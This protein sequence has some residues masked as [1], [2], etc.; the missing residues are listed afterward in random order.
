MMGVLC[1]ATGAAAS[2]WAVDP[3]LPGANRAGAGLSLFEEIT[4]DGVPFPYEALM[5][6]IEQA[7]GCAPRR[8]TTSVLIPLGR[9][10]QRTAAAP[11]YFRYP[12][13]VTAVIDD[14]ATRLHAK[15]RLFIGYQERAELIEVISY[16]ETAGRF[17]F[18]LVRDYR[19]GGERRIVPANRAVCVACHQNHAPIFSRQQWD[20]TN[21]NPQIADAIAARQPSGTPSLY[22]VAI[23]GGVD[24]P[25]AIDDAVDRANLIAVVQRIWREAC[26][27]PCRSAVVAAALQYRLS[28]EQGFDARTNLARGFA[29]SWPEG[30]AVPDPD[31]PNRDPLAIAVD[32]TPARRIDVP[33]VFDALKVRGPR[34]VWKAGDALLE[35]RFV[36]GLATMIADT[37]VSAVESAMANVPAPRRVLHAACSVARGRASCDGEFTLAATGSFVERLV[38]GGGELTEL[39]LSGGAL[40]RRGKPAR[41]IAGERIERLEVK[42]A[43]GGA[44]ATLTLVEDFPLQKAALNRAEWTD[45]FTR[46]A[47][48][49]TLGLPVMAPCCKPAAVP[50]ADDAVEASGVA[51]AFSAPC[52]SCH[53]GAER[54]PP[55]FLAGDSERVD[56]ALRR[57]AQRMF[58][59][60][61]MWQ[62]APTARA[63]VPMPPPRAALN[64]GPHEQLKPDAAI[65]PL[66]ATVAEW[67]RRE[68]GTAP[69]VDTL[70]ARGYENLRPCLPPATGD[71]R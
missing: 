46:R 42:P 58:V 66:Q 28:Q 53:R 32:L 48:R 7:T 68:S 1:G 26:D 50:T 25:N 65:A 11:D 36:A 8:C 5:R 37:D 29:K 31:L 23:R 67:L 51:A 4:A 64:G 38:I 17:E 34:D 57:C 33:A 55:N 56:A 47:L 61:A 12:R 3:S 54:S 45:V 22:G 6:K 13:V 2:T 71:A 19:A 20:E 24:L 14:G 35:A 10:L 52:G 70:L 43:A 49:A 18:Q 59:R 63:K 44:R 30:L 41:T 40:S 15:D 9:S 16:N 27:R 60:L 39:S 62:V 21:A 69:E